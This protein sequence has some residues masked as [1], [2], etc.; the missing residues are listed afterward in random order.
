M[1]ANAIN[2]DGRHHA[3][4]LYI[5][6]FERFD[7]PAIQDVVGPADLIIVQRNF[8]HKEV[9]DAMDYWRG[10]HKAVVCDLDDD[11]PNLPWSNPAHR[12]WIQNASGAPT[13]P[14]EL[15][16]AGLRH[17]NALI[18]PSK[19]LLNDWKDVVFGVHVPNYAE[20]KWFRD[21]KPRKPDEKIVIG[22]GGSVSHYDS[23]WFSEIRPAIERLC[24]E[25]KRVHV[26]I[27]GNDERILE[28]L[29]IAPE[30]KLSQGG[31]PAEK[32]PRIVATFDIGVAPLDARDGDKSYDF[33]RSWIKC[34]EYNLAQ[35]PWIATKCPVYADF[36]PYG[37]LT[38]NTAED[39]Y[40]GLKLTVDNLAEAKH[41][42]HR[43]RKFGVSLTLERNVDNLILAY[44]KI[45]TLALPELPSVFYVNWDGRKTPKSLD[46]KEKPKR[47]PEERLSHIQRA[48]MRAAEG[49]GE[50]VVGEI[51]IAKAMKYD[52]VQR[53]NEG[54]LGEHEQVNSA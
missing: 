46:D 10:L 7:D 26:L 11:Y 9:W 49:W 42:A 40:N 32:W 24:R 17:A 1:P 14:I 4:L 5:N 45:Q 36:A 48:A 37:I 13:A 22:W 28:Q 44:N 47:L 27:C 19:V 52:I 50:I 34:L 15:L 6:G 21:L 3:K 38:E 31:V 18:A 12:F 53:L 35:V 2:K 29:D 20:W 41:A 8:V 43:H 30:Q 54:L 33:R 39:W 16:T 23:W 25:D 51:N